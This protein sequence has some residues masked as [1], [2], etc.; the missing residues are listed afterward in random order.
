MELDV[1]STYPLAVTRAH[2]FDCISGERL[3]GDDANRAQ[4]GTVPQS[5]E[6]P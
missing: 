4:A 6:P 1:G 5:S 2:R 3:A